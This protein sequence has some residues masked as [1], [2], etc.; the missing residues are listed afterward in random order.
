[1]TNKELFNVIESTARKQWGDQWMARLSAHYAAIASRHG[2]T[3]ATAR[4]RRPQLQRAFDRKSCTVE[5]LTWLAQAAGL[6]ISIHT[7]K[8][9]K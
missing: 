4:S 8:K 2:D 6:D 9:G 5:T 3:N 7:R 1:M